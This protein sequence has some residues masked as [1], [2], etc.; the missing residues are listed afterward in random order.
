MLFSFGT[1]A[2]ISSFLENKS[3]AGSVFIITSLLGIIITGISLFILNNNFQYVYLGILS[4]IIIGLSIPY[5]KNPKIKP[6]KLSKRIDERITMFSRAELE[7]GSLKYLDYYKAHPEHKKHDDKFRENNGL[8][9]KGTKYYNKK[10]FD[11]ANHQFELIPK[12]KVSDYSFSIGKTLDTKTLSNLLKSKIIEWG[13]HSVGICILKEEHYYSHK[14]RG[15]NYGNKL[16]KF[17]KNAIVFTVEM[18]H[19]M[20]SYAPQAP[21]VLESSTQYLNAA[22]IA[23]KTTSLLQS[24]GYDAKEHIDG[25]YELVCP[26]VAMDAGLGTIGRMGLLMTPDLGPRVRIAAISTNAELISNKVKDYSY[27]IDFC[28]NCLKCANNCPTQSI[29]AHKYT[30][31]KERWKI[32]QEACY[33]YWT[34]IGTDCAK[35]MQVCPFSHK[36]NLLHNFVRMGIRQNRI[37]RL[38]SIKM[39]DWLY[40]TKT[41]KI[42]RKLSQ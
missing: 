41:R 2:S 9:N 35:C 22:Q 14:G 39:D 25:N 10:L 11:Q 4:I 32:N 13:G 21:V 37:F 38:L 12:L 23:L 16:T 34:K 15:E 18:N 1:F 5:K 29:P 7:L 8:L 31:G 42:S 20:I 17:H 27:I 28:N 40:P 30:L 19:E 36:N 33:T 26:L 3:R 6:I 24:I